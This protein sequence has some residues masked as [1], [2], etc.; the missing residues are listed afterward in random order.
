MLGELKV[1]SLFSKE[2]IQ[3]AHRHMGKKK[4][5]SSLIIR[6]RQTETT[7]RY[8]LTSVKMAIIKKL[9]VINRGEGGEKRELSYIVGGNVNWCS[10]YGK[11]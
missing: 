3:M 8:Q 4:C 6:E 11:Q 7:M 1:L 5:S 2:N 9:Q 10:H